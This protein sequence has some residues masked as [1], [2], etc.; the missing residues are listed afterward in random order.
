VSRHARDFARGRAGKPG[1]QL[2]YLVIADHA[3]PYGVTF[4]GQETV[5][6]ECCAGLSTV[7]ANLA[8]LECRR[9]L[10]RVHRHNGKGW[11][12]SDW[13]ILA[14]LAEDRGAMLDLPNSDLAPE[15]WHEKAPWPPPR[16]VIELARCCSDDKLREDLFA[17]H[18]PP[19]SGA[20]RGSDQSPEFGAPTAE[21][22]ESNH[23]F[24][25]SLPPNAE[26]EPEAVP[27]SSEPG[28]DPHHPP[29]RQLLLAAGDRASAVDATAEE[30]SIVSPEMSGGASAACV[31]IEVVAAVADDPDEPS[32]DPDEPTGGE[33]VED[34][35]L[36]ELTE[37]TGIWAAKGRRFAEERRHAIDK[38][39]SGEA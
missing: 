35:E 20:R 38:C 4:V 24:S 11:R 32:G 15:G 27:Q 12:T 3:N 26:G 17:A 10:G 1:L 25:D 22:Q 9:L 19:N 29:G 21:S 36:A 34:D 7:A 18:L 37:L 5:A 14:P 30:D 2:V 39:L 23:Q 31:P 8:K 33:T 16:A 28:D 13:T 6:S